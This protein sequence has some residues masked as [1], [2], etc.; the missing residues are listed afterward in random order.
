[1]T[2]FKAPKTQAT[3]DY[4][5]PDPLDPGTYPARLVQV[6]DLGVQ[7]QR[8]FKGQPKPDIQ[9]ISLTYELVDTFLKDKDGEDDE[10]R[11]RW[12]S[13][14]M[15]LHSIKNEKA[16]STQRYKAFDKENDDD[17]DWFAQIG[18]PVNVTVAI[19]QVDD[20]VYEN[21]SA[22]GP[23]R[24][25]DAARCPEL[26]NDPRLFAIDAEDTWG[27]FEGLPQWLRE[28]IE[29]ARNVPGSGFATFLKGAKKKA[30]DKKVEEPAD[31][32]DDEPEAPPKKPAKKAAKKAEA[33]EEDED[34]PW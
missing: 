7:P 30:D 5:R 22:L 6:I 13:E 1:M 20:K 23:M 26:V 11:P 21:V 18:K 31:E 10:A 34:A 3:G 24:D 32:E 4:V 16:K 33:E 27:A 2:S 8:P 14:T 17:G 28:K 15:P 29:G 9:M 12:L 19:N 25:R